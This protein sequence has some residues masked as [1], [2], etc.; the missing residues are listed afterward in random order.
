MNAVLAVAPVFEKG[1]TV[2]T[3]TGTA[4]LTVYIPLD[5]SYEEKCRSPYPLIECVR[6][7][8]NDLIA[9]NCAGP[10]SC[11]FQSGHMWVG[12]P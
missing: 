10:D 4:S 9:P 7:I 12:T 1:A 8:L 6:I 5:F 2:Y 11:R 3:P